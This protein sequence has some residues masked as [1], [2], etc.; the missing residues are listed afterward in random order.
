MHVYMYVLAIMCMC[1]FM[2]MCIPCRLC[3]SAS[4]LPAACTTAHT[5]HT[6]MEAAA[7]ARGSTSAE[8]RAVAT[9]SPMQQQGY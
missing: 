2:F 6:F 3:S 8:M 4:G 5:T 1:M 7:T 9:Y